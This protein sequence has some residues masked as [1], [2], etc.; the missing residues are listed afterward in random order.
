MIFVL[1]VYNFCFFQP[2]PTVISGKEWKET[3]NQSSS[4]KQHYVHGCQSKLY[5]GLRLHVYKN[6]QSD[7]INDQHKFNKEQEHL[8]GHRVDR[9]HLPEQGRSEKNQSVLYCIENYK[10]IFK[11]RDNDCI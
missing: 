6:N 7:Y 4:H 9:M 8:N 3:V 1:S 5:T 2:L 11:I 10:S